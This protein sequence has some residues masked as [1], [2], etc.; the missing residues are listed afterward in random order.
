[1]CVSLADSFSSPYNRLFGVFVCCYSELSS[2]RCE[3]F[4][5][6][7]VAPTMAMDGTDERSA[8][9]CFETVDA[10]MRMKLK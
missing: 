10:K 3:P 9:C 5:A 1:M 2:P 6:T 8:L 4:A 7:G